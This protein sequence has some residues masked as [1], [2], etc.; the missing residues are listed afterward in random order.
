[1]AIH[2]TKKNIINKAF[3]LFKE[4]S[5]D[6]VTLNDICN[7][8]GITKTTF[9]YHLSSKEEIISHFYE[10]VTSS[11]ADRLM[12]IMVADNYWEQFMTIFE[13][14][15]DRTETIGPGLLGQLMIMNLRK[16]EGTFD[17]DENL[18]KVAVNL[19]ERAQTSGQVRNQ[20]QAL[21]LYKAACHAFEGYDLLWCIKKG[22]Y[23]RKKR[24]RYAFEQIFDVEPALRITP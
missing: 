5:Y 12:E 10:E 7:A 8:C 2:D 1:M 3:E 15:I 18:T 24:L 13:S 19:L 17:F 16:D 20:S 22:A 21:P 4:Q 9:Y 23:E 11:L 14:L 6:K